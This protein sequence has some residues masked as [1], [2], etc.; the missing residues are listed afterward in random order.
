MTDY[1]YCIGRFAL[2]HNYS[3]L[4]VEILV[5]ERFGLFNSLGG[6][7]ALGR[8]QK[9][10]YPHKKGIRQSFWLLEWIHKLQ[11]QYAFYGD[12][13]SLKIFSINK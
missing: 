13:N 4:I 8:K 2:L 9:P 10:A 11:K 3:W 6:E 1:Y 12:N 7:M 5:F